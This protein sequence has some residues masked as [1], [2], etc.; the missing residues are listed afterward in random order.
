MR[1]FLPKG[2]FPHYLRKIYE[3]KEKNPPSDMRGGR[4]AKSIY[5]L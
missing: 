1:Q 4:V 5:E 2:T 3:E